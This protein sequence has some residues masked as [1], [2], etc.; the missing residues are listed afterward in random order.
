[1]IRISF[2]T[3]RP[4]ADEVG[5]TGVMGLFILLPAH[6]VR[7]DVLARLQYVFPGC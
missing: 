7:R 6:D 3:K 4:F 1:M 5:E 2:D